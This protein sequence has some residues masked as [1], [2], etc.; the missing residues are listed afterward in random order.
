MVRLKDEVLEVDVGKTV[1][2]FLNG[3]IKSIQGS[4]ANHMNFYFNS[5]MVRLKDT[6]DFNEACTL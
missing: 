3:A 4:D 2:Q 6:F 5:S 1:F